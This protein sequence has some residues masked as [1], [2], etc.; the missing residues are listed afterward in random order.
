MAT[1]MMAPNTTIWWFDQGAITTPAAPKV[2]EIVA[3]L[4]S[5]TPGGMGQNL[6]A[7][8]VAGYTLNPADSDT[9]NSQSIIDTGAA[10]NRAAANYEGNLSFFRERVPLTNTTS[11]Y[12]KTYQLFKT[13]GRSGWLV[14]RVGK[15]YT[16]AATIGDLV[17]VFLFITDQPRSTPPSTS[18]GPT[19]FTVPFLKQGTLYTN[20]ALVA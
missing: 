1:K 6:S 8:V 10:Q 2:T 17:D 11:E 15:L 9:D 19:Q 14:R 5:S 20:V 18:G 3:A 13:K 16:V 4:A 12:L 7:A